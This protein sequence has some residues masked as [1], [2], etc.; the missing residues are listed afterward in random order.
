[1]SE[2][3]KDIKGYEGIYQIS[4]SGRI[5]MIEHWDK[6]KRLIRPEMLK[7]YSDDKGFMIITLYDFDHNQKT[8]KVLDLINDTFK[9]HLS[10]INNE[11]NY[12]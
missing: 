5:M 9:L 1:M 8:F 10:I 7:P 2:V 11:V 12:E 3:W 6:Y 4:D